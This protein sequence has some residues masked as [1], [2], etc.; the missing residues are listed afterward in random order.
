[1]NG[2]PTIMPVGDKALLIEFG[3]SIDP[4]INRRVHDLAASIEAAD[5]PGV[6]EMI[7]T[8]RSLLISYDPMTTSPG[9]LGE[10]VMDRQEPD[11]G[12]IAQ[13]TKVVHIP[14]LYAGEYGPDIEFVARNS[15]L[16]QD[17]VIDIHSGADYLVYMMG[18]SSGFPYLGGLDERL[19]TPRLDSPR[20]EVPAGSVGIAE[21]QT[22]VYPLASPAGWRLIGRTPVRLFDPDLDPPAVI[23]AGDHVRFV[24]LSGPDEFQR[25]ERQVQDRAYTVTIEESS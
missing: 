7:P 4:A 5:V 16:S 24:P 14:T 9:V 10:A 6:L 3:D 11:S 8:Y 25:I 19:T 23:H 12:I 2:N 1:M 20:T 17:E 15:G 18:F 21:T 22:G 13:P